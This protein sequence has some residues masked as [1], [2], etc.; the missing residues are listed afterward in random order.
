VVIQQVRERLR[1]L[2]GVQSVTAASPLP[3]DG[4]IAYGRWGT[5]DAVA[6]PG[7]F[8]EAD[9]HFVL[10]G[11]FETLRTK[12]IE[13]RTFTDADN[14]PGPRLIVIDN[15]LA[16]LAFPNQ[17]AVGK[18]L[19][20]R[21]RTPEP[22]WFEVIG[23]VAH[24]R[25][26]SLARPGHEALFLTDDYMGQGAVSRWAVRSVGDP[27][28]LGSA[29]RHEIASL[30]P[31][32]VVSEMQPMQAFVDHAQAQTRFSL[33][34]IAIFAVIAAILA[35]VGLHGVLSATVRQRTAEIG[36]RMALG[37]TPAG[38][39]RLMVSQGLRLSAFGIAVGLVVALS[40]TRL[41]ASMLVGIE[42]TDP[43]TFAAMA[44]FFFVIATLSS[45]L[46]ARR[47]AL[48]DP[49]KALREE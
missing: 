3:L 23:V 24:Q 43:L 5:E 31:R 13:G 45:W 30:D 2:P 1:A 16:A 40:L 47:A 14:V 32:L 22:E 7:K 8:H 41:M 25:H 20:V 21:A 17:S 10:P 44:L 42:P 34:L 48:L 29:I 19:L 37:A 36:V 39:F 38:I 27:A 6:N 18:R 26:T 12:L 49:T 9:F 11:Y 28:Q 4:G 35:A 46:P 33:L 15:D